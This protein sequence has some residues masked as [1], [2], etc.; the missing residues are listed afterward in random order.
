MK[1]QFKNIILVSPDVTFA[2]NIANH[3]CKEYGFVHHKIW[4]KKKKPDG[5]LVSTC[6]EIID[7]K[8]VAQCGY[9]VDVSGF[10]RECPEQIANQIF[11]KACDFFDKS[12]KA[13]QCA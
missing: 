7:A 10:S 4:S 11:D 2:S 1:K 3:L 13:S 9:V 5:Y 8:R 6:S 12:D